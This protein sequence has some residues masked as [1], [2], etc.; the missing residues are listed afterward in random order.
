M[1]HGNFSKRFD[2]YHSESIYMKVDILRCKVRI[3]YNSKGRDLRSQTVYNN[4]GLVS[5]IALVLGYISIKSLSILRAFWQR[6]PLALS[7][8]LCWQRFPSSRGLT[9][10][11]LLAPPLIFCFVSPAPFSISWI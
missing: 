10:S 4:N 1:K 7:N 3:C 2:W 8:D 9:V 6:P 11:M 5:P